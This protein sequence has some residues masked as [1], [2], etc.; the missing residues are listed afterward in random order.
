MSFKSCHD[1]SNNYR[2]SICYE[3]KN[4]V[5]LNCSRLSVMAAKRNLLSS[6]LL[7]MACLSCTITA[8]SP[9]PECSSC[10]CDSAGDCPDPKDTCPAVRNCKTAVVKDKCG[11]CD[12]C[13]KS[14][15]ETCRRE[16][17]EKEDEKCDKGLTCV[18]GEDSWY[19]D[20]MKPENVKVRRCEKGE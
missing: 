4:S 14:I 6:T 11:C 17:Q 12:V 13:L 2:A 19:C 3:T 10:W 16:P 9:M 20:N 7:F 5:Y 18:P 15:G 8:Q 1:A